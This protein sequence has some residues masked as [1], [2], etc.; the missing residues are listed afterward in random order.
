M[1]VAVRGKGERGAFYRVRPQRKTFVRAAVLGVGEHGEAGV[2][3]VISKQKRFEYR[4]NVLEGKG[5]R[6][7]AFKRRKRPRM[8]SE[9]C[10]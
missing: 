7:S 5:A 10:R 8:M 3:C 2:F 9:R 4:W 6:V 1:C